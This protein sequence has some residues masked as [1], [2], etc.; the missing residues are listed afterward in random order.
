MIPIYGTFIAEVTCSKSE[1]SLICKQDLFNWNNSLLK[2]NKILQSSWLND[3]H[4]LIKI[5]LYAYSSWY[6]QQRFK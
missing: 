5:D 2:S 4:A 1:N 6:R 3:L